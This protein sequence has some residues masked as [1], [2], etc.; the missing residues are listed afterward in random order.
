M[1]RGIAVAAIVLVLV[2]WLVWGLLHMTDP[3]T[4]PHPEGSPAYTGSVEMPETGPV[5][6]ERRGSGARVRCLDRPHEPCGL[7]TFVGGSR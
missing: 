5:Q 2:A 4:G 3:S 7:R 1:R 6:H